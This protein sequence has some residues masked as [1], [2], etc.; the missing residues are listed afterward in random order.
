MKKVFKI[1]ILMYTLLF[2]TLPLSM[3]TA[4]ANS[5]PTDWTG[6]TCLGVAVT[7]KEV[8]IVVESEL[9]TFDLPEF[10]KKE[11]KSEEELLAY[12]GKVTAQYTFYNPTD[13]TI[14]ANL[15]FPLGETPR[16]FSR[17]TVD[18]DME[19]YQTT[20]NGEG[21]ETNIRHSVL[22]GGDTFEIE[23]ELVAFS[24]TFYETSFLKKDTPVHRVR[25]K[26]TSKEDK[27]TLVG[28]LKCNW[29]TSK[30]KLMAINNL[31]KE[32]TDSYVKY[33][34]YFNSCP[35]LYFLGEFPEEELDWTFYKQT[36][37]GDTWVSESCE[38]VSVEKNYSTLYDIIMEKYPTDWEISELD[39][40]NSQARMIEKSCRNSSNKNGGWHI[41]YNQEFY[42]KRSNWNRWYE[43]KLE[44]QPKE[45]L[46]NCVTAP[47]YP[48]YAY[49]EGNYGGYEYLLSPAKLWASFGTLDIVVNTP[50]YMVYSNGFNFEKTEN[51][52]KTSLQSLP[53][54]ELFF[55]LSTSNYKKE[56]RPSQK[57]CF[58]TVGIE[59]AGFGFLILG[60]TTFFVFRKKKK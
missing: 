46:V 2:A 4:E 50:Y 20:V 45:R 25:Y 34:C 5:G 54:K 17:L 40:Y 60:L 3:I 35:A 14:T 52:Y 39:W 55:E 27:E 31:S 49:Y 18:C 8:P 11:Y 53:N 30:T 44:F 28:K 59:T 10:P 36:M 51:G 19:K 33:W 16:F 6:T 1:A 47:F 32:V 23:N 37:F 24:D 13:Y 22:L 15:M 9:L 56:F 29:D 41:N 43:Y 48:N 57:G 12:K 26:I 7:D 38:L 42:E 58:S 21:I